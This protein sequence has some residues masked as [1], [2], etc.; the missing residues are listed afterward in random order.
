MKNKCD[1][2]TLTISSGQTSSGSLGPT[3]IGK[4]DGVVFFAPSA[5]TG[6][7]TVEASPDGTN[8][9][10]VKSG[11]VDVE[12]PVDSAVTVVDMGFYGIRLTSSASEASD[13][14]F[15]VRGSESYV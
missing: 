7:V 3:M 13:R 9:Y 1:L 2:G 10:T 8:W 6:T 11:G 12:V 4:F 5:L 14:T 15:T